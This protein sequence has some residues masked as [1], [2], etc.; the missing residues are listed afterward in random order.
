MSRDEEAQ[1]LLLT[2]SVGEILD[3]T[4]CTALR[5]YWHHMDVCET[6]PQEVLHSR[7]P[8][9]LAAPNTSRQDIACAVADFVAANHIALDGAPVSALARWETYLSSNDYEPLAIFEEIATAASPILGKTV[10]E[11][12]LE[13]FDALC[14]NRAIYPARDC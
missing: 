9:L 4:R 1:L 10:P 5:V 7:L 8:A 11:I 2:M 3:A 14:A 13:F 12:L 6:L